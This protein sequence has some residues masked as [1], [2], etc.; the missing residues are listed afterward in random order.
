MTNP[1][2]NGFGAIQIHL[3]N[4]TSVAKKREALRDMGAVYEHF[5]SFFF[6]FEFFL[7]VNGFY[8][9][10]FLTNYIC[11]TLYTKKMLFG[12]IRCF[13]SYEITKTLKKEDISELI[14]KVAKDLRN[15][16]IPEVGKLLH[17]FL[18]L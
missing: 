11:Q 3:T 5:V 17:H 13:I 1:F 15:L 6:K 9:N 7:Y 12:W 2:L 16:P 8:I 10:L 4:L 18:P 14:G